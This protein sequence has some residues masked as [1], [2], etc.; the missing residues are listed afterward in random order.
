MVI[1]VRH[2]AVAITAILH[3]V[4]GIF[5]VSRVLS[6]STVS[7]L[8]EWLCFSS[9]SILALSLQCFFPSLEQHPPSFDHI[10]DSN[11]LPQPYSPSR[12]DSGYSTHTTTSDGVSSDESL[13]TPSSEFEDSPDNHV[14]LLLA[15]QARVRAAR[16]STFTPSSSLWTLTEY[17]SPKPSQVGEEHGVTTVSDVPP[18]TLTDSPSVASFRSSILPREEQISD[19]PSARLK[20]CRSSLCLPLLPHDRTVSH[21][22]SPPLHGLSR[23]KSPHLREAATL[24]RKGSSSTHHNHRRTSVSDYGASSSATITKSSVS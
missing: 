16:H 20:R 22:H 8:N 6:L 1:S 5:L 24:S 13:K 19:A 11:E 12:R 23:R 14:A 3:A 7:Y 18:D 4:S 15:S 2:V 17:P 10:S 9:Q 21:I